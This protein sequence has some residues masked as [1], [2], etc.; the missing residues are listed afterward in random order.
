MYEY[1]NVGL[2]L[3][4]IKILQGIILK[5]VPS[6]CNWKKYTFTED[7]NSSLYRNKHTMIVVKIFFV[8]D[9]AKYQHQLLVFRTHYASQ[10]IYILSILFLFKMI[11]KEMHM[12]HQIT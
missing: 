2:T 7:K 6:K 11:E 4:S 8:L 5:S 10:K 9:D 12:R 3:T 1:T